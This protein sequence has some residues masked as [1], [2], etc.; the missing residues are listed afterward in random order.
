MRVRGWRAPTH[1]GP[2]DSKPIPN[3]TGFAEILSPEDRLGSTLAKCELH[4][5]WGVPFCW[6]VDPEKQT[7]WQYHSGGE[8]EHINRSGTLTA[9]ELSV[10]LDELF[11]DQPR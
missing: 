5:A 1:R 6:V 2:H 8:P 9:G 3:R 7:A 10:Q 4:H 11:S